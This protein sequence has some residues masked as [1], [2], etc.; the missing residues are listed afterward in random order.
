MTSKTSRDLLRDLIDGYLTGGMSFASFQAAYAQH[1]IEEMPDT[2]LS[3]EELE[4]Y[5]AVHEKA[6]WTSPAP[7]QQE[8]GF[9]WMD[10]AEFSAWLR[11]WKSA[12]GSAN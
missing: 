6:E 10:E 3:P 12:A 1:F 7:S 5:G 4:R 9:G 2:A 8:R 11:K